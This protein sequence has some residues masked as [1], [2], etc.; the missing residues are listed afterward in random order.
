VHINLPVTDPELAASLQRRAAASGAG[1]K[2][3]GPRVN[4]KSLLAHAH[5]V[6]GEYKVKDYRTR[7]GTATAHKLVANMGVPQSDAERA[8]AIMA[9][10]KHVSAILG[11]T[12]DMARKAYIAPSVFAHWMP[13]QGAAA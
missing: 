10:A 4:D 1:G 5:N 7:L 9:V 12:P 2:I 6:G 13:Q 8:K 11:N 3:F